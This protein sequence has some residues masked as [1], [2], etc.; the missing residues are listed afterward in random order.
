MNRVLLKLWRIGDGLYSRVRRF[1][2]EDRWGTNVFRV[3][4]RPY[5]GPT[6]ALPGGE[7]VR[8][9]DVVGILHLYNLRLQEMLQE[10]KSEN[11]RVLMVKREVQRSLPQLAEFV[12]SHPRG[13]RIKALVG[14]TLLT[15]GVEPLGFIVTPLEDTAWYRFKNWYMRLFVR[16]CHPDGGRR[17]KGKKQPMRLKRIVLSLEEL[18]GRYNA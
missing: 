17:L 8:G 10:I 13:Q 2:F 14:V 1:D 18:Y 4:V 12:R 9:G 16:L 5:V 15:R 3:R 11:R 7:V 6:V